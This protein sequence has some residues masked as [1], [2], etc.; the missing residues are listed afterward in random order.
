MENFIDI[1]NRLKIALSVTMDKEVAAY[2]GLSKSAF[3]ER[4]KRNAFPTKELELLAKNQ[5]EL[6]LDVEL[7]LTGWS[8]A[9]AERDALFHNAVIEYGKQR[10]IA[11]KERLEK[12]EEEL[13]KRENEELLRMRT[14][15]E[16]YRQY[17]SQKTGLTNSPQVDVTLNSD[18]MLL[19]NYFR[20]SEFEGKK[21]I[22]GT[23]QMA[24][25]LAETRK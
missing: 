16:N 12:E 2:L 11:E 24:K 15:L 8:E 17:E 20:E 13:E 25:E 23:A 10:R 14:V 9:K 6:G 18:E 7:I 22:L 4:K 3:A 21:L 1:V 19:I 5:P